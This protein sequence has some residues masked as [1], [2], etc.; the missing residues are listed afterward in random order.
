MN[1]QRNNTIAYQARRALNDLWKLVS[2]GVISKKIYNTLKTKPVAEQRKAYKYYSKKGLSTSKVKDLSKQVREIQKHLAQNTAVHI[3][4]QRKTGVLSCAAATC[5]FAD[6][7]LFDNAQLE[8]SLAGL[9]FFDAATN[10]LVTANISSLTDQQDISMS[11][12]G[13]YT[14]VNNYQIPVNVQLIM[15]SPKGETATK[16]LTY[17]TSG[18]VDQG[19]PSNTSSLMQFS[20]SM[21]LKENWKFESNKSKLVMPGQSFSINTSVKPFQYDPSSTDLHAN[22]YQKKNGCRV[23]LIKLWGVLGHDTTIATEQGET[24]GAVDVMIEKKY[25]IEYDAGIDLHDIS[26]NDTN[27]SFTNAGVVSSKPVCDNISYSVA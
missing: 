27:D 24:Q 18:L 5:T 21:I 8:A 3:H 13:K 7:V 4:R 25:T 6:S 20:D 19:N 2:L 23:V 26:L 11:L 12:Y 1:R 15:V 16:P 9:R 14:V 17:F 10:A 22:A